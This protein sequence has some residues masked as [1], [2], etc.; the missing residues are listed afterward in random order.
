[1]P[2]EDVFE[3]VA[4]D[5]DVDG[6]P[7]R[8]AIPGAVFVGVVGSVLGLAAGLALVEVVTMAGF[9]VAMSWTNPVAYVAAVASVG[10][11]HY[12]AKFVAVP[13]ADRIFLTPAERALKD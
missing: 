10:F 9:S 5:L 2:D 11:G 8:R 3:T 12:S 1:V 13:L 7:R 4:D 6:A